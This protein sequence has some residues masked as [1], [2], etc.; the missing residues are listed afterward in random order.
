MSVTSTAVYLSAACG[1]TKSVVY[2]ISCVFPALSHLIYLS[3]SVL[4]IRPLLSVYC[5]SCTKP[6]LIGLVKISVGLSLICFMMAD[7]MICCRSL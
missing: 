1:L 5:I 4:A 3:A 7:E 2:C 6:W